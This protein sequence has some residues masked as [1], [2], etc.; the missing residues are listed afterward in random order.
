VRENGRADT[1]TTLTAH[2]LARGA[3]KLA[4]DLRV[5]APLPEF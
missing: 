4:E 1:A 3:G 2:T 5:T